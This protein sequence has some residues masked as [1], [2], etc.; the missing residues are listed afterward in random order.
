[1]PPSE[2]TIM[3][4]RFP[5]RFTRLVL[6]ALVVAV[7]PILPQL[8]PTGVRAATT[9]G[10]TYH[11]LTPSR[12]LDTR[13]GTGGFSSPVGAG[14]WIN[15]QVGGQGGVPASGVSAVVMNVTV[16]DTTASSYLIVY[17][18]G[19]SRPVASN[20]NWVAGQTVPNLV[21]VGLGTGNQVTAFNGVGSVNVVFDVEG[22]Y[23][24]NTSSPGPD[25]LFN[26]LVPSRLLDTRNGTG[27]P[28]AKIGQNSS[29]DLQVTGRG[30][31]PAVGVEA[32]VLNV[33]VT[34]PTAPS[35]LTVYPTGVT[36]PVASNLNFRPGQTVPNRVMVGLGTAGKVTIYNGVGATDVVVDVNGWFTDGSIAGVGSRF[37]PVTPARILD[38]RNGNGG[39]ATPWGPNSANPVTVAGRGGVPLM[40]DLNVPTAVVAN[41]TVTDTSTSS[42]LVAWPDGAA[43]PL[44]SDLNWQTGVTVPNLAV[45]Q[46]GPTGK[47]DMFN[48]AGCVDVVMDVVGWF[49]G[50]P[51]SITAGTIPATTAC[52]AKEWLS[53]LNYWRSTAGQAPVTEDPTLSAGDYAHA[54]W[55]IKNQVICHCETPGTP[56]YSVAGATAA[57]NSNIEVS[58]SAATTDTHAIDWWMAAPFHATAMVDPRLSIAGYGAYR[59]NRSGWAAGFA[60]DVH[61][62]PFAG[63]YPVYWPNGVTV[64]LRTY[65]GNEWPDPLTQCGYSGTV[66]LPVFVEVGGFVDTDVTNHAF[67]ANGV[68]IASCAI[69]S[70]HS[71]DP[72]IKSI[73]KWRGAV[74]VIPQAALSPGVVYTVAV[75]V[76]GT[77]RTWTFQVS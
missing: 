33:T 70:V 13:N 26:P 2:G 71:T 43:Q 72:N 8:A 47:V 32:V 34:G 46:V 19:V 3:A 77:P 66:G 51:A 61:T 54:I 39:Y 69:D 74:I 1:M 27:A 16:T 21:T 9:V 41:I 49:S 59:E 20:L 15:V 17:P 11:P 52:P 23:S 58:S 5:V 64:P 55:M 31:V 65:S 6:C 24:D 60:L 48:Y 67:L 38:S 76:N 50:G 25:G 10:G 35:Y 14:G 12:I 30:L 73:L 7:L 29:L 40:T 36:M 4:M 37:M 62:D 44:A 63:S 56:Y 45:L 68:N 22:Y 75:T 53:R 18:T 28:L 42:A 57:S